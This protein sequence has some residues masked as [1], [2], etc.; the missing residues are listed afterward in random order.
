MCGT[1]WCWHICAGWHKLKICLA[2]CS[3]SWH[4]S[5]WFGLC[6][7][8]LTSTTLFGCVY[9]GPGFV[10]VQLNKC[11]WCWRWLVGKNINEILRSLL[12]YKMWGTLKTFFAAKFVLDIRCSKF[13]KSFQSCACW[14]ACS[15][16]LFCLHC[17]FSFHVFEFIVHL[18]I[19]LL[20]GS[21]VSGSFC[22]LL[23]QSKFWLNVWCHAKASIIIPCI[24]LKRPHHNNPVSATPNK[25]L[26]VGVLHSFPIKYAGDY[27]A[28]PF[29]FSML[30][31]WHQLW[32]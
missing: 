8:L 16:L 3:Y 10:A 23:V 31:F 15:C 30:C 9:L 25:Q 1:W 24:P 13:L 29:Y 7:P 4:G 32:E 21:F 14:F 22:Q 28:T 18:I 11:L 12:V 6:Q 26:I 5:A 17:R 19:D 20:Y 2:M 27:L